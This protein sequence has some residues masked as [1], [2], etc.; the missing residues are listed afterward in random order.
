MRCCCLVPYIPPPSPLRCLLPSSPLALAP[1]H[2]P[3][4]ARSAPPSSSGLSPSGFFTRPQHAAGHGFPLMDLR[5]CVLV[6]GGTIVAQATRPRGVEY[7]DTDDIQM[8]D[9]NRAVIANPRAWRATPPPA[10]LTASAPISALVALPVSCRALGSHKRVS[11]AS[12]VV[13]RHRAGISNQGA[14]RLTLSPRP[15]SPLP[16]LPSLPSSLSLPPTPSII[17]SPSSMSRCVRTPGRHGCCDTTTDRT[18]E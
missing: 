10:L 18:S 11:N 17:I 7:D 2:R 4:P 13:A 5:P 12:S 9:L 1:L 14:R 3:F 16:P 8:S 15:R 6:V